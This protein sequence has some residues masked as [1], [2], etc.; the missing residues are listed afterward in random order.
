MHNYETTIWISNIDD[1][2]P[3]KADIKF[4]F[5]YPDET[6]PYQTEERIVIESITIYPTSDVLEKLA[7]EI[8]MIK[9]NL[10]D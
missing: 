4:S 7:T 2:Y 3:C 8:A 10:Q 9:T 6:Y 5:E 1:V